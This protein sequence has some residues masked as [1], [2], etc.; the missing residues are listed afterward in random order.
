M[1]SVSNQDDVKCKCWHLAVMARLRKLI[2]PSCCKKRE[3]INDGGL[4][5]DFSRIFPR[6]RKLQNFENMASS[7]GIH[8]LNEFASR[9]LNRRDRDKDGKLN[10]EEFSNGLKCIG[11]HLTS[12][13]SSIQL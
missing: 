7:T 13:V 4:V 9:F 3:I 8:V 5:P 2:V 6:R 12:E 10:L 1:F 11:V